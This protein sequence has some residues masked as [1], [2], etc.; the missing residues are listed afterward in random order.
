M[1]ASVARP[2]SD[3]L[4]ASPVNITQSASPWM[5]ASVARPQSDV[6]GGCQHG[7][8]DVLFLIIG[9]LVGAAAGVLGGVAYARRTTEEAAAERPEVV[10]A[11]HAAELAAVRAQEQLAQAALR[12]Q[13][14]AVTATAEG[15]RESIQ[16]QQE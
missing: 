8:M 6:G 12:E 4:P 9:L 2:Q 3:V 10:A 7:D 16:R 13:L 14:A 15:L 11:R 5:R 1:R